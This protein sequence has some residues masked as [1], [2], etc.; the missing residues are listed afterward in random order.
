MLRATFLILALTALASFG[1]IQSIP[2][3]PTY[4]AK[5][6]VKITTKSAL[7]SG[8]YIGKG[9]IITAAHVVENTNIVKIKASDG[10]II[11][12]RV[13]WASKSRDVAMISIAESAM[14]KPANL[15]CTSPPV[16]AEFYSVGNPGGIE[17]VTI[18]GRVA[19]DTKRRWR[20]YRAYITDEG[21][22]P[23]QSGSPI[24]NMGGSVIGMAAGVWDH[25]EGASVTLTDI[26]I[27]V[28][29]SVICNLMG[30]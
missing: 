29:S 18:W 8:F 14:I 10:R 24:F 2:N 11:Y 1:L 13:M 12:G 16:G 23:G 17:F 3:P 26:G 25:R 5:S 21:F 27:A 20:W 19:S 6:A 7:G 30:R 4:T 28:P 9:K 15:T 22:I